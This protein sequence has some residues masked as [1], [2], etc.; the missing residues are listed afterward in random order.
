MYGLSRRTIIRNFSTISCSIERPLS[1]VPEAAWWI[2]IAFGL[3][4]ETILDRFGIVPT[5]VYVYLTAEMHRYRR[6]YENRGRFYVSLGELQRASGIRNF[7]AIVRTLHDDFTFSGGSH[8]FEF[9]GYRKLTFTNW[10]IG[11][12]DGN[13]EG[14]LQRENRY[15]VAARELKDKKEKEQ[16]ERVKLVLGIHG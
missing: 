16:L 4:G 15:R 8:L 5:L 13:A 3:Y 12:E 7:Y 14:Y 2:S 1:S 10:S 11:D 6:R 9:S